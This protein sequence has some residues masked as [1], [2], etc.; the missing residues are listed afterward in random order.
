MNKKVVGIAAFV[1]ASLLAWGGGTWFYGQRAQSESDQLPKQFAAA[2]PYL[3]MTS[4]TY[5]AGFLTSMQTVKFKLQIPMLEELSAGE[6]TLQN[7]IEH[8]PF[9][10][11]S[12]A[13]RLTAPIA[14]HAR[15]LTLLHPVRYDELTITA[16][17]PK[18]WE[19]L[20]FTSNK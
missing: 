12:T 4:N 2:A 3:A 13:D 10:G 15:Q 16:P 18:A 11:F 9:P 6:F 1:A 7:V 19:R 5:E 14:L 20:G 17:L 8:G